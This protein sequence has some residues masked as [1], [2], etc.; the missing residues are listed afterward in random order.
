MAIP[1]FVQ[2]PFPNQQIRTSLE[3][4]IDERTGEVVMEEE[5]PMDGADD[6]LMMA[7]FPDE[8]RAV[9]FVRNAVLLPGVSAE[10]VTLFRVS[11]EVLYGE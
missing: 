7:A 6:V 8:A 11:K 2:R 5:S 10:V 9:A 4:L 3:R 1:V